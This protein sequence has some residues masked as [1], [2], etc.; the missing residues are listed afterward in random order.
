MRAV[1]S[2]LSNINDGMP[3]IRNLLDRI[4]PEDFSKTA[5]THDRPFAS[6]QRD[7]MLKNTGAIQYY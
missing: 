3:A 2:T 1:T 4:K 7:K 5:F 6:L